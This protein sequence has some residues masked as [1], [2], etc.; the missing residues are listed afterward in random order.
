MTSN[1]GASIRMR[2]PRVSAAL[3]WFWS[4]IGVG[5]VAVIGV[6]ANNLYQLNLTV[7]RMADSDVLTANTLADHEQRIRA[8]EREQRDSAPRLP[9]EGACVAPLCAGNPH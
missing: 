2:D 8:R 7:G 1:D 3:R 6:A 9:S 4:M 5:L